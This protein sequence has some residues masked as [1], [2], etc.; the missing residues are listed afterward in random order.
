MPPRTLILAHSRESAMETLADEIR[1]RTDLDPEVARTPEESRELIPGAEIVLGHDLSGELLAGADTVEW[2]QALSAGVDHYDLD[3]LEAR[4]IALTNASGV[5]A[6]PIAEQ[7]LGYL[8]AFERR[9][10]RAFDQQ[11]RGVW[12]G[13]S[14]AEL[15]GKEVCV[16]GLGAIGSRVAELCS[17]LGCRVTGT[18]RT[19]EDAPDAADEVR[20]PDELQ[21]LLAD[22]DHVVVAC[23]L[24]EETRGL[25]GAEAFTAM[26]ASA[27]LTNVARGG[28]VEQD[29]LVHALQER[30]IRGAALDV[31]EEEPL[32][33]ESPLWDLSNA[34]VTPHMAG[35]TPAYW[36]RVAEVFAE[37]YRE[38]PDG[39]MKNRIV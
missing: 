32:P 19:P 21:S 38:Y 18:K 26:R 15:R 4:D 35:S 33:E 34:I 7:V 14:A 12:E 6:E 27:T 31:F 17:A 28:I 20:P 2:M 39:E 23:P 36:T 8:L 25:F 5:H 3:A 16:V 24:T 9:F 13:Y 10:P 30:D 29:E 11:E 37:S 1:E 22:A